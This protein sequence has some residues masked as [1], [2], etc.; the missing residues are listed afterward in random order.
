MDM[1]KIQLQKLCD[2]KNIKYN[3]SHSKQKL[4]DLLNYV[5]STHLSPLI[6]WS[7]GKSDEIKSFI[8]Y[9]PKDYKTYIEPFVG[10]GSLYFYLNHAKS[11]IND[12]HPELIDFYTSISLGFS[13]DIFDWMKLNKNDEETYYKVRDD[14]KPQ[15]QLDKAKQFYYLR[16]TC[17]RGML[18]YNSS[19]KFNIP[20]GRYKTIN[21][22]D[23][24]NP[25][26]EKLLK[27]TEIHNISF[28]KI[29][30]KYNSKDN[31]VFLDPPYDSPFTDYGYCS[32]D[33]EFQ[34]K[35]ALCFKNTNNRCLMIIGKTPFIEE[36][37]KDYIVGEYEKK[38]KFKIHSGRVGNEINNKHLII[39]N[40]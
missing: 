6:K 15:N 18:R 38:Y 24:N 25:E 35:L 29:F 9:L 1:T 7:G 33:K 32:F 21:Y 4:V 28:E 31:F 10:G 3:K 37:Y 30:E 20:Y 23:L 16:K 19:G 22:D 12:V 5:Q 26:Y 40:Y 17:F 34:K 2:E 11:I 8:E 39:K 27:S 14:F 36:L 13:K